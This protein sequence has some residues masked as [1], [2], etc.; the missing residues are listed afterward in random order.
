MQQLESL[1]RLGESE[2][3]RVDQVVETLTVLGTH[4]ESLAEVVHDARNMVTALDLYCDLLQEPGVLAVPFAHYGAE[5]RL[6]VSAS[7]RLID[8]LVALEPAEHGTS[9]KPPAFGAD[10]IS[11]PKNVSRRHHW[12]S[13]PPEPIRNLAEELLA[14]R[15]L[16]GS[17]A[18]P[19]IALTVD[20]RGGAA[21][22]RMT[23]EDL[24]RILVNLVKNAAE[25][26]SAAGHIHIS[27]RENCGEAAECPRVVLN[28]EDNGPGLSDKALETIFEASPSPAGA[29]NARI[30]WPVLHRGLGLSIT[31]SIVE[32][33]GG[34]IHAANRDPVGACFQIELPISN[35]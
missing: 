9:N 31:R 17:L 32:N 28:V 30:E 24:T 12:K 14:N 8:K 19:R 21:P 15:N 23:A 13:V 6:V 20:V 27:L 1:P 29:E 11:A 22:V 4:G 26:M 10:N 18:G 16:L 33:A 35:L 7:R 5:L 34:T 3:K 25:A 2:Q